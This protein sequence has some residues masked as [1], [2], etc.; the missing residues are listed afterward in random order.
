MSDTHFGTEVAAVQ[1]ALL[2]LHAQLEPD[3]VVLSGDVTQRAR[4]EQFESAARFLAALGPRAQLAVPGNH[5]LPLFNALARVFFPYAGY[6][7][8]FGQDLEPVFES[9]D[10]LVVGVNTTRPWRWKDGEISPTQIGRVAQRVA[11]GD[12]LQLKV[13]VTH[14]PVHIV[15]SKDVKNLV[16]DCEPAVRSWTERGA[17]LFLGGH[18]HLPYVRPLEERYPGLPRRSWI[19]QAGTAFSSRV[20]GGIPNAVNVIRY[21]QTATPRQCRVE[22]WDFDPSGFAL[23]TDRVLELS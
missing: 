16:H 4:F 23:H 3:L 7:R 9:D 17:D 6:R 2:A 22:R 12:P 18:I 14:Q 19:A 10:L 15:T 5:D 21:D 1:E 13:I 11:A 8:V 20:R